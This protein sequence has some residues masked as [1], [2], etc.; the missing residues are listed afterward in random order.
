MNLSLGLLVGELFLLVTFL[1]LGGLLDVGLLTL[2]GECAPLLANETAEFTCLIG[3]NLGLIWVLIWV[4]KKIFQDLA[5]QADM[6]DGGGF[7][8]RVCCLPD[9]GKK[10]GREGQVFVCVCMGRR[11]HLSCVSGGG[12]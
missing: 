11:S 9:V 8:T 6:I 3:F 4:S 1:V 10:K 7:S 12:C 2:L 5:F